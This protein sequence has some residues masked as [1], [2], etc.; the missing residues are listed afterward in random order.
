MK[1]LLVRIYK[2]VNTSL[3]LKPLV[4]TSILNFNSLTLVLNAK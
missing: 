2:L 3:A 4:V 1:G